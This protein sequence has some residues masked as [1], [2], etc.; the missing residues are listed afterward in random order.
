MH[1]VQRTVLV[2]WSCNAAR[3]SGNVSTG[4]PVTLLITGKRGICSAASSNGSPSC[5]YALFIRRE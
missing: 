5:S 4:P 1:S 3:I 2:T